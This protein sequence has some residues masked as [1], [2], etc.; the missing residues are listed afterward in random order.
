MDACGACSVQNAA[1]RRP[2]VRVAL[3]ARSDVIILGA[4]LPQADVVVTVLTTTLCIRCCCAAVQT[5][6]ASTAS[7]SFVCTKGRMN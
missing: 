3:G 4:E 7:V 6:R 2:K 1:I 5:A